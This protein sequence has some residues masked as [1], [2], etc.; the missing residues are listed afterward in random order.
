LLRIFDPTRLELAKLAINDLLE[1]LQGDR[2]GIV[3]FAGNSV[4]KCPLTQ[5]YAFVKMALADITTES[6]SRGGTMVGM[7]SAKR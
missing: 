3:T 6:T 7:P 1:R 2:I 4:V 5:D